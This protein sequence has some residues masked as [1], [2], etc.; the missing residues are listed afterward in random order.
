MNDKNQ[1]LS[2]VPVDSHVRVQILSD[3]MKGK[4]IQYVVWEEDVKYIGEK[5]THDE[6][7]RSGQ[8][9]IEGDVITT[10]GF[11]ITDRIFKKGIDSDIKIFGKGD[12]DLD[13]QNYFLEIIVKDLTAE[14]KKFG[15]DD[16]PGQMMEVVRSAAVVND[17]KVEQKDNK[18]NCIPCQI[19]L[20]VQD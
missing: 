4:F 3:G 20:T 17:K 6:I 13:K 14:S 9:K 18:G 2:R 19:G 15:L 10:G 8:I 7:I 16:G 5:N 11:T 1:K 12:P